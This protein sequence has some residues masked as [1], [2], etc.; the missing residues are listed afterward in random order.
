MEHQIALG[1]INKI[2]GE[3]IYPKIANK[4]DKYICPD[5]DKDLYHIYMFVCK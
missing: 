4:N 3:Y 2:T 5:C 1:A